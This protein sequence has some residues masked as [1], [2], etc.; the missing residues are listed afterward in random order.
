MDCTF[1]DLVGQNLF[2]TRLTGALANA[3]R[4]GSP[5]TARSYTHQLQVRRYLLGGAPKSAIVMSGTESGE[6]ECSVIPILED[7]IRRQ[8]LG[9]TALIDV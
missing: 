4:Y 9:K 5:K 7:L 2:S 3:D 8:T 1:A 6:T